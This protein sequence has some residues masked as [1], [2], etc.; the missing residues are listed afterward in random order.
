MNDYAEE[1]TKSDL[2]KKIRL[3]LSKQI[4]KNNKNEDGVISAFEISDA[5]LEKFVP[6][7]EEGD[8]AIVRI[9]GDFAEDFA[10]KLNK[11][12]KKL[13]LEKPILLVPMELRHIIFT[14]LSNYMNNI[15]VLSREEIGYNA[16]IELIA[17]I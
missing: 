14:L 15:T 5:T 7:I 6:N 12:I 10:D 9:D 2:I 1:S 16:P 4:C 11:K 17:E 8:D 3:S 13:N